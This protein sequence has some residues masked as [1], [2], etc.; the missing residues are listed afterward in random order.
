M[1]SGVAPCWRAARGGVAL[2]PDNPGPHACPVSFDQRDGYGPP[3][4]GPR[5][6]ACIFGVMFLMAGFLG[7]SEK[8]FQMF[9]VRLLILAVGVALLLYGLRVARNGRPQ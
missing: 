2:T 9:A 8:T 5:A 4:S 7:D 1:W 3:V 6:F